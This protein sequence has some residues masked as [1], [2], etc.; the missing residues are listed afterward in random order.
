MRAVVVLK[1]FDI[2]PE[3]IRKHLKGFKQEYD[4]IKYYNSIGEPLWEL[5]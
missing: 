1:D 2:Y 3:S 5:G 4:M